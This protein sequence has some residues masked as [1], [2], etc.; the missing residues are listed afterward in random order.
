ME[1]REFKINLAYVNTL[2]LNEEFREYSK[3]YFFRFRLIEQGMKYW[4]L[5]LFIL[6]QQELVNEFGNLFKKLLNHLKRNP[7]IVSLSDLY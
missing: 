1:K 2:Y 7:W 3:R 5:Y 4:I 6:F